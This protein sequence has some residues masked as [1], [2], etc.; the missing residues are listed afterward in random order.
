MRSEADSLLHPERT[1]NMGFCLR[2][3][4]QRQIFPSHSNVALP[5]IERL[6]NRERDKDINNKNDSPQG[7]AIEGFLKISFRTKTQSPN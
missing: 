1:V 7:V 4:A 2:I 6:L 5:S 3:S